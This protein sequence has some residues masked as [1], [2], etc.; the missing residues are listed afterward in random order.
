MLQKFGKIRP[1]INNIHAM[2]KNI[3]SI[4]VRLLKL[5]LSAVV[6]FFVTTAIILASVRLWLGPELIKFVNEPQKLETF[7]SRFEVVSTIDLTL[8]DANLSWEKWLIPELKISMLTISDKEDKLNIAILEN[9]KVSLGAKS[10]IKNLLGEIA[11][12][13]VYLGSLKIYLESN[14]NENLKNVG[15]TN[16]DRN[17]KALLILLKNIG[18]ATVGKTEIVEVYKNE[19]WKQN[20]LLKLGSLD[21]QHLD[22]ETSLTFRKVESEELFPIL[23]NFDLAIESF[24]DYRFKGMFEEIN[25][26]FSS[27]HFVKDVDFD[28][29]AFL[30][31]LVITGLFSNISIE[32][33]EKNYFT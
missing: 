13:E 28:S 17:S 11:F 1:R 4:L 8:T 15:F 21:L 2:Q 5:A 31:G 9:L 30:N 7:L 27:N 10:F 12:D 33:V 19:F 16:S 25:F 3:E 32:K 6:L 22:D 24:H 18:R 26:S 29:K 20:L 23:K 14:W